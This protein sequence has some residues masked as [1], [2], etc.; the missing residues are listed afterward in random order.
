MNTIHNL[1]ED[2]ARKDL[3]FKIAHKCFKV[4]SKFAN[5]NNDQVDENTYKSVIIEISKILFEE[6]KFDIKYEPIADE[7]ISGEDNTNFRWQSKN[8]KL[9]LNL[10]KSHDKTHQ[11]R[12][13]FSKI[14]VE[15]KKQYEDHVSILRLLINTLAWIKSLKSLNKMIKDEIIPLRQDWHTLTIVNNIRSILEE[16]ND[17]NEYSDKFDKLVGSPREL[18]EYLQ[19]V[20]QKVFFAIN[21]QTE[22][23]VILNEDDCT[24]QQSDNEDFQKITD[25]PNL[26]LKC[27]QISPLSELNP[28]KENASQNES[29]ISFSKDVILLKSEQLVIEAKVISNN[30]KQLRQC[31]DDLIYTFTNEKTMI[32]L[33]QENLETE[34]DIEINETTK[35]FI[36][37]L[38]KTFIDSFYSKIKQRQDISERDEFQNNRI[39]EYKNELRILKEWNDFILLKMNQPNVIDSY[40]NWVF[41]IEKYLI[42][43]ISKF[44]QVEDV[45]VYYTYDC[46]TLIKIKNL[47]EVVWEEVTDEL[48]DKIKEHFEEENQQDIPMNCNTRWVSL[49]LNDLNHYFLINAE[50]SL[51]DRINFVIKIVYKDEQESIITTNTLQILSNVF[52][53]TLSHFLRSHYNDESNVEQSNIFRALVSFRNSKSQLEV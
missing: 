49:M 34:F 1:N 32:N 3:I 43:E 37:K 25:D 7:D 33:R 14:N 52:A 27:N 21:I 41:A 28:T 50:L 6:H 42:C 53:Q 35:S 51:P 38:L 23:N 45:N 13:Y 2:I 12:L 20:C 17:I 19:N 30:E 22:C 36:F 26:V 4:I 24:D 48:K 16:A 46:Q 9:I 5:I 10:I 18:Q 11:Y 15:A 47:H 39:A 44:T 8:E 40:E 31:N 29:L